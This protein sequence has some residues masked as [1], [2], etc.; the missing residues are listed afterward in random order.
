MP[1][2]RS[3]EVLRQFREMRGLSQAEMARLFGFKGK[4]ARIRVGRWENG[5]DIPPVKYR[6]R[7]IL[8][9]LDDL[10]LGNDLQRFDE[11]WSTLTREWGWPALTENERLKYTI[12]NRIT[13]SSRSTQFGQDVHTFSSETTLAEIPEDLKYLLEAAEDGYIPAMNDVGERLLELRDED[14]ALYW[15]IKAADEGYVSAMYEAG[16]LLWKKGDIEKASRYLKTAA[17]EGYIPAMHSYATLLKY[18]S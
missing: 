2:A 11:I 4:S 13:M 9:L 1:D 18:K 5:V 3:L 6:L 17:D 16:E 14:H 15:F 8:Y 7:F 10:E 12:N